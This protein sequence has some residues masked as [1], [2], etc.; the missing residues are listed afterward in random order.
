MTQK[1]RTAHWSDIVER[2]TISGMSGLAWCQEHHINPA[3]FYA[4]RRKL[5]EPKSE[6]GFIELNSAIRENAGIRICLSATLSIEVE[7]GF[8]PATLGAVIET[9]HNHFPC[10][11]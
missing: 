6:R 2:Q 3:S 10:S 5:N 7:R 9:L 4:W 11:D 8:D 1:E